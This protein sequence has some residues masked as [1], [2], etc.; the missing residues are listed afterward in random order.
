VAA[1]VLTWLE[2][3]AGTTML[4]VNSDD[5]FRMTLGGANP[6]DRFAVL[7]GEFNGGRPPAD[8]V[9]SLD[10]AA[11]GLYAV[12]CTWE[13]G[14]GGSSLELFSVKPDGTRVLLNDT[15]NGGLPA[16]RTVTGPARA[17]A[18]NLVPAQG[19]AM[20]P[21]GQFRLELVD[22]AYAI[23]PATIKLSIDG[24]PVV[25]AKS[26]SG[27]V[28]T[29]TYTSPRPL[30]GGA[31]GA[32][33][34]YTE[35][36]VARVV[37]WNFSMLHYVGPTG[38]NY[39][40]VYAPNISWMDAKT[41]AEKRTFLCGGQGHLV[42]LTSPEE[43]NFVE[44]L[45][46]EYV[47]SGVL[48]A[49][50]VWAGGYQL[51]G[52]PS[53][54]DGWFWVNN[55][56]PIPPYNWWGTGY[57]NWHWD[58]PNDCCNTWYLEDDEE[59]YLGLGY[60][61]PGSGWIDDDAVHGNIVGYVVEYEAQAVAVDVKPGPG[62]NPIYLDA[63]GK[64]PVAVLSSATFDAAS[65]D[66]ATVRFGRNGNETAP[67][68]YS[69]SDVNGDKRKD[70]VCQFNIQDTG[71]QCGDT[72]AKLTANTFSGCSVRGADA[73]QILRCP[74]YTLG[75]Q[76]MQDSKQLTDVY[77][78]VTPALAG[79][80]APAVAQNIVLKSFDLFGRL[81]WTRTAQNT[82]LVLAGDGT[83]T[84][85]LQYTDALHGQNL[86]AQV[87]VKDSATGTT[88]LLRNEGRV[89]YRPDLAVASV[90]AASEVGAFQW[91]PISVA[92]R[93]L[94]G[95]LG[96]KANVYLKD[97][98]T[99]ID[100]IVGISVSP[101]TEVGLFFATSF[102]TE[103][104]HRLKVVIGDE[105]PG[106]FDLANNTYEFSVNVVQPPTYYCASYYLNSSESHQVEENDYWIFRYDQ[107]YTEESIAQS[108]YLPPALINPPDRVTLQIAIDGTPR[109]N[110]DLNSFTPWYSYDDGC[111]AYGSGY[112]DLG[113][114]LVLSLNSYRY[115]WGYQATYAT[116]SHYTYKVRYF[117]SFYQKLT[118]DSSSYSYDYDNLV[119]P[120]LPTSS[121]TTRF[122][123]TAQGQEW[124]GSGD[125]G[126]LQ[127]NP[128]HYDWDYYYDWWSGDT[129]V[130]T[131]VTGSS[132][133]NSGWGYKCDYAVP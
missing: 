44:L 80:M 100:Q 96:A 54:A 108:L 18:R 133:G 85:N 3:P 70:L 46:Q 19:G 1:E 33:V 121:I 118:G 48:P 17:Y 34:A 77:L 75:V 67:L 69:L 15:A 55:E 114:G 16:Y 89:L 109:Y 43:N 4:G 103:G 26:K 113:D 74:V 81:R 24:T 93:E 7:V 21:N 12:R 51:P 59:N 68:S 115:C 45:R 28:T 83:S 120:W 116:F 30:A 84:G 126:P 2:L 20:L 105:V 31:H 35:N 91:F 62:P 82:P 131:H 29:V 125:F 11:A 38:N 88:Q 127:F 79:H 40:F 92:V 52:Q 129:L 53:T 9:F 50:E 10:V 56:G 22:G 60:F 37:P 128:F 101:S 97:G 119:A 47:N 95:D 5:G 6:N 64:L 57:A 104:L 76:A 132:D 61:G 102:Q 36:G 130:P 87:Q 99:V 94:K 106:D 112:F 42:T 27:G 111:Y 122:V 107:Q 8:T 86:K 90:S 39:E 110:F 23:D 124:G 63:P 41:A 25:A 66:P 73:V 49:G 123:V 72:S 117:S 58:E 65:I 98:D 32:T 71:L 14:L 13:Q 78:T